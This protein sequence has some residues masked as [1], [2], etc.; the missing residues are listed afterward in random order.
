MFKARLAGWVG[1]M[2]TYVKTDETKGL[3]RDGNYTREKWSYPN[4]TSKS[5]VSGAFW[6]TAINAET[7]SEL[8]HRLPDPDPHRDY[9]EQAPALRSFRVNIPGSDKSFDAVVSFWSV[10]SKERAAR[11]GLPI[12]DRYAEMHEALRKGEK[13][14]RPA[15]P[16]K[17]P[18]PD[19]DP[20]IWHLTHGSETRVYS[21]TL[22]WVSLK[23]HEREYVIT[24]FF[25]LLESARLY[26][27]M[28]EKH[29]SEI[30]FCPKELD[31]IYHRN[32]TYPPLTP[33]ALR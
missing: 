11:L 12:F 32:V 1:K 18:S 2:M 33:Y 6:Y 31:D 26:G 21:M 4:P 27:A 19:L 7:G 8:G 17:P 3:G 10:S 28:S 23:V 25:D 30:I 5:G 15:T 14:H 20:G 9:R 24:E 16:P 29:L 22:P 13:Y